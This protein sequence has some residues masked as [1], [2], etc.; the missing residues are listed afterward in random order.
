MNN[1]KGNKQKGSA[2]GKAFARPDLDTAG[3]KSESSSISSD[4]ILAEKDEVK[5]AE[6]RLRLKKDESKGKSEN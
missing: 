4:T 1:S 2:P 3:D 6:E 5:N